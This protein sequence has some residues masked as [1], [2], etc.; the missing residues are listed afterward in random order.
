MVPSVHGRAGH[1]IGILVHEVMHAWRLQDLRMDGIHSP[2]I[3]VDR[4]GIDERFPG[5]DRCDVQETLCRI[6]LL[7]DHEVQRRRGQGV[8]HAPTY[9]HRNHL[10]ARPKLAPVPLQLHFRLP[11]FGI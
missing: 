1:E 11:R 6:H 5:F 9:K 3:A 10:D 7:L 4:R 2:P 8:D